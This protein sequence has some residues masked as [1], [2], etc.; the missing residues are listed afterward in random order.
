[1]DDPQAKRVTQDRKCV[2]RM[3]HER[4]APSAA[5]SSPAS[6]ASPF[7]RPAADAAFAPT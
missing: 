7:L 1:M 4:R 3:K 6:P 5:P 2:V